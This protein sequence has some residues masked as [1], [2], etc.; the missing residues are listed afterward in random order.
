VFQFA[1][2]GL[3]VAALLTVITGIL[4]RRAGAEAATRSFE[5]LSVVVAGSVLAPV[6]TPSIRQGDREAEARLSRAV[7]P[8]LATDT[9]TRISVRDVDGRV[10]WSDMPGAI[11]TTQPV[12]VAERQA[13]ADGS[14]VSDRKEEATTSGP[15]DLVTASV[16][17]RGSDGRPV[18]VQLSQRHDDMEERALSL[19]RHFAPAALGALL[20]LELLQIPL[21]AHLARRV[22][23]C[24]EAESA[25]LE[26][27]VVA[28][29]AERR[30]VAAEVHDNIVPE[31]TGLA[32]ELDAARLRGNDMEDTSALLV[33]TAD[34]VRRSIADL[35]AL[36]VHLN[37]SRVSEAGL[38]P[39]VAELADRLRAGGT[40]VNVQ[41]SGLEALPAA[42]ADVLHRCV[43]ETLRN[44]TRHSE[45]EQV[46]ISI[47]TDA[48]A[49]T[50]TVEDDGRGFDQQRLAA[51]EDAGHL[52]LRGLGA[53][54][55]DVGGSLTTFSAPGQG[56][57][58]V[59][60]IPLEPSRAGLLA[61]R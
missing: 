60:R 39:A 44:V 18:L 33:R 28:A 12:T 34:G 41:V 29:D 46:D 49:V 5:R 10:L 17:V 53:L 50:M 22:R 51:S 48:E 45:A 42:T 16:G 9:L 37:H 35:R 27:A 6:L 36:S 20:V 4:A 43:Q 13:L 7:E 15:A 38:G 25:M 14:V 8:L 32:Y 59:V 54:A 23:R 58:V 61:V 11:G 55:A 57:R 52:G 21:A 2:A 24:Q 26:T 1:V 3:L 31:L 47:V 30:R 40:R 56:T 19:W